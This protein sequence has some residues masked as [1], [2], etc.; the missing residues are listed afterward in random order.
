MKKLLLLVTALMVVFAVTAQ[1]NKV[2]KELKSYL[3]FSAGPS[4]PAGDFASTSENNWNAGYAKTGFNIN[5]AYGINIAKFAGV[6]ISALYGNHKLDN[7]FLE[8]TDAKL[9]HYQYYGLMAGPVFR[10]AGDNIEF[11]IRFLAG[12]ANANSPKL[13]VENETVMKEDWTG[14]FAWSTGADIRYNL[15][16]KIFFLLKSDYSEMRPEFSVTIDNERITDKRRMSI[17]N[18]NLGAGLRF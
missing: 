11:S 15:N 5:L 4:F 14:T 2:Q 7:S 1:E 6:E 18:V 9:D 13:V 16:R 8:G 3:M 10:E 17:V 12:F